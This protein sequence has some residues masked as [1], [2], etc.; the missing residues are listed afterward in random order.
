[1]FIGFHKK[2]PLF[3]QILTIFEFSLQIIEKYSNIK[4]YKYPSWG[5]GNVPG[6][7][8]DRLEKR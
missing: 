4:Y 3:C 5:G 6:G 8:T 1:M 2:F 7:R